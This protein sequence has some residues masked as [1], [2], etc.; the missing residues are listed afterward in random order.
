MRQIVAVALLSLALTPASQPASAAD[1][2]VTECSGYGCDAP[3]RSDGSGEAVES[4]KHPDA[5]AAGECYGPNCDAPP[6]PPQR[7]YGNTAPAEYPKRVETRVTRDCYD[8][9]RP[10][11]NYDSIEVVKTRRD[12]DRSRVIRTKTVIPTYR[13]R[14]ARP[15]V[16]VP[17]VTVVQ[18]VVHQYRVVDTPTT[19]SYYYPASYPSR[20]HRRVKVMDCRYGYRGDHSA[21]CRRPIRARY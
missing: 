15:V 17:V 6:P 18:Y 16:R 14:R 20:V 21:A 7:S 9:D 8:C 12:V 19:Y 3:R 10:R 4:P 5:P 2:V 13:Y 11:K 1:G